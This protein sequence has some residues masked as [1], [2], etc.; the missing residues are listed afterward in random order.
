MCL[1]ALKYAVC[2]HAFIIQTVAISL[3]TCILLMMMMQD[4]EAI[5]RE[6][7]YF[8]NTLIKVQIIKGGALFTTAH[9]DII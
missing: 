6:F 2:Y 8:H 9:F 3:R 1:I 7:L 4:Y 5:K